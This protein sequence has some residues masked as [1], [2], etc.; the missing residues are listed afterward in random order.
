MQGN[1]MLSRLDWELEPVW[2]IGALYQTSFSR[3]W[4]LQA[5]IWSGLPL[6][7]GSM[8]DYDWAWEDSSGELLLDGVRSHYSWHDNRLKAH[9]TVDANI[10]RLVPLTPAVMI[11]PGLGFLY[12]YVSMAGSDGGALYPADPSDPSAG[13]NN[14]TFTGDVITYQH[15]QFFPYLLL[16]SDLRISRHWQIGLQTALSPWGFVLAIDHHILRSLEFHDYIHGFGRFFL[17]LEQ[18]VQLSPTLSLKLAFNVE[19][20]LKISGDNY[21]ISNNTVYSS[22]S[23]GATDMAVYGITLSAGFQ[24]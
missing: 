2:Q 15:H 12:R 17:Q 14:Y 10:S 5:G 4:S 18:T 9:L 3:N 22:T 6:A 1:Y 20:I 7:S 8:K 19:K 24:L 13:Y 16:Q 23:D 21:I 11:R